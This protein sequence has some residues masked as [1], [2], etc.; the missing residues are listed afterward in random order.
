[1]IID[2]HAHF[3]DRDYLRE[4]TD[5]MGLSCEL[6][7][8][9][10]SLLRRGSTTVAWYRDEFFDASARIERMDREGVDLRILSLSSPSVYEWPR[11]DQ[12]GVSRYLNEKMAAYCKAYPDRFR[13]VAVLPLADPDAAISEIRYAIDNL[14]A[15]GISIGSHV[16]GQ[17][18]N[19]PDLEG[20]WAEINRRRLPVI[21]HPMPALGADHL[22]EFELPIRVGFAY[23]TTT[24]ITRLIYSGVFERYPDFPFIVAHTGGAALM[25]L[26]RLDNGYRIFPDCRKHISR[27]PSEF[28][29]K[30]YYDTCSFYGPALQLAH[31]VVGPGRLLWGT[32]EPFIAAN[33]D[34]VTRLE[35]SQEETGMVLGG[36][37]ARLF[38]LNGTSAPATLEQVRG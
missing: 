6:T 14:G 22:D 16:G 13:W 32:D 36:N 3:V 4:L 19:H 11:R 8:A 5:L 33:T 20:V 28:A 10:Q 26:E 17:P 27:L 15:V 12:P 38:G 7:E 37:A 21:E 2:I 1:M 18:L 24:A 23:E 30:L 9:G 29:R 34:H 35:M 31:S 25:L